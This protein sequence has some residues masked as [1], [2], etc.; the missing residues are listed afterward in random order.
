MQAISALMSDQ[1]VAGRLKIDA[2][3]DPILSYK[4]ISVQNERTISEVIY[5]LCILNDNKSVV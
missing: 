5:I 1:K 4:P 2:V 3:K